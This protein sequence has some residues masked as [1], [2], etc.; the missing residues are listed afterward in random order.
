MTKI[1]SCCNVHEKPGKLEQDEKVKQFNNCNAAQWNVDANGGKGDPGL[2][3]TGQVEI[4]QLGCLWPATYMKPAL[5]ECRKIQSVG[6]GWGMVHW[7]TVPLYHCTRYH[8]TTVPLYQV[9]SAS[10]K[11]RIQRVGLS[12]NRIGH[13]VSRPVALLPHP[14]W[15][16]I[17]TTD[18]INLISISIFF[19][20]IDRSSFQWPP[21]IGDSIAWL[22]GG[23]LQW[24]EGIL[25]ARSDK[26]REM[27]NIDFEM[28]RNI[29]VKI[30]MTRKF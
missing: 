19:S 17:Q 25:S 15:C 4:K 21:I 9:Q 7:T 5:G 27:P 8:C 14:L 1:K 30:W 29:W 10:G 23:W 2:I 3:W 24:G 20:K 6:R 22:G 11:G 13:G 28:K 12:G 18:Q 26:R 16:Q